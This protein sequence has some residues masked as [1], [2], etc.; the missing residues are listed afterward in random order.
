MRLSN[1]HTIF[2]WQR[3]SLSAGLLAKSPDQFSQSDIWCPLDYQ[4]FVA[5]FSISSPKPDFAQTN[6]GM[7]V[8][9]PLAPVSGFSGYYIGFLACTRKADLPAD[10]Q[11]VKER[12]HLPPEAKLPFIFSRRVPGGLPRQFMRTSIQN[13][14]MGYGNPADHECELEPIWISLKDDVTPLVW[15]PLV[16]QTPLQ[17]PHINKAKDLVTIIMERHHQ[18]VTIVTAYP[19]EAFSHGNELSLKIGGTAAQTL[20]V[21]VIQNER[22]RRNI[23]IL[24]FLLGS[25]LCLA[26][27]HTLANEDADGVYNRVLAEGTTFTGFQSIPSGSRGKSSMYRR[28]F[29]TSLECVDVEAFIHRFTIGPGHHE[30]SRPLRDI[31]SECAILIGTDFPVPPD[32]FRYQITQDSWHRDSLDQV[33]EVLVAFWPKVEDQTMPESTPAEKKRLELLFQM[34]GTGGGFRPDGF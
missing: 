19:P 33:G 26:C 6:F 18:N 1:D 31:A 27:T 12:L 14:M 5:L 13:R 30:T 11:V 28:G 9:L 24:F 3:N 8:Q 4:K 25:N 16:G 15:T 22:G 23:A 32:F 29:F 34:W 10:W 17:I 7:H 20:R 21:M 2:T